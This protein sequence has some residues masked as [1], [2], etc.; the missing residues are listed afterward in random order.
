M[1][2]QSVPTSGKESA[3]VAHGIRLMLWALLQSIHRPSL[4]LYSQ[5]TSM[6][7]ISESVPLLFCLFSIFMYAYMWSVYVYVECMWPMYVGACV[8]VC[9]G[10]P[11]TYSSTLFI[12]AASVS[13]TQ[14]PPI[15]LVLLARLLWESLLH[16]LR[17]ALQVGSS[18]RLAF[19]WVLGIWTLILMLWPS[20][21]PTF[22]AEVIIV[23][24][25]VHNLMWTSSYLRA[26]MWKW[27]STLFP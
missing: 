5:P 20:P 8:Q 6:L 7:A 9:I 3:F 27:A 25:P 26:P 10:R 13:Q 16:L 14:N 23:T 21:Q 18:A 15:C 11:E 22:R 19:I 24:P 1:V 2:I 4:L 17:L 12:E